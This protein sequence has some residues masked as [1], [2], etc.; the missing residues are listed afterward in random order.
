[1]EPK[2]DIDRDRIQTAM[3]LALAPGVNPVRVIEE[4]LA[5]VGVE[6]DLLLSEVGYIR[7]TMPNGTVLEET[8]TGL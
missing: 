5:S 4:I 7:L 2:V 8:W 1:M 3:Q 6:F